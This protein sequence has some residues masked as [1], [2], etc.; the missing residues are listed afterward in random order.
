V[1]GEVGKPCY[2]ATASEKD[3]ITTTIAAFNAMGTYIKS[4]MRGKLDGIPGSF[5]GGQTLR[6]SEKWMGQ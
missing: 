2:K 1:V 3:E 6:M 5:P 4:T